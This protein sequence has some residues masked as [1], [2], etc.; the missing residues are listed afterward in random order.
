M[1]ETHEGHSHSPGLSCLF[2]C[3]EHRRHLLLLEKFI[4]PHLRRDPT[5]E[6]IFEYILMNQQTE[7]FTPGLT[8]YETNKM[9]NIRV[10]LMGELYL[11]FYNDLTWLFCQ[12][13][14]I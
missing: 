11:I 10:L 12:N 4:N 8:V 7:N 2:R 5:I 14:D 6:S 13:V 1:G 3:S 9:T